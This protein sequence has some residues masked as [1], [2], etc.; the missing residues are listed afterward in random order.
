MKYI[1][2]SI[3]ALL[4]A[5]GGSGSETPNIENTTTTTTITTSTPPPPPP[6]PP[7]QFD[8]TIE[9]RHGDYFKPVI[10]TVEADLWS[11]S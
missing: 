9:K 4:V 3:V 10:I 6:P 5:C 7:E 1:L 2:I 8:V 11:L